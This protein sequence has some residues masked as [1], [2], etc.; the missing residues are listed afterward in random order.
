MIKKCPEKCKNSIILNHTEIVIRS[1]LRGDIKGYSIIHDE[2]NDEKIL[3][4]IAPNLTFVKL[5]VYYKP[6]ISKKIGIVFNT[7]FVCIIGDILSFKRTRTVTDNMEET[8]DRHRRYIRAINSPIRRNILIQMKAGKTTIP[9]L[10]E[11]T[12]LDAKTLDWHIR[13]LEHGFCVERIED[14]GNTVFKITQEGKVVDTLGR[15]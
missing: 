1:L 14:E 9:E 13:M 8:K 7:L 6:K 2:F 5:L 4:A 3:Q 10:E 11:A 15:R 12:G